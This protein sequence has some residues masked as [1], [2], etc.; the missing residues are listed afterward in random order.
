MSGARPC[1]DARSIRSPL[2]LALRLGA[3]HVPRN[4]PLLRPLL[5]ARSAESRTQRRPF[6]REASSPQVRLIDCPC[7]NAGSTKRFLG[8]ESFAVIGP[9]ALNR[10]AFYPVSVRHPAGL[11]TPLLSASL[12]RFPLCGS[13][14][15]LRPT[16][17]RTSTSKSMFMLGTPNEKSPVEGS[18]RTRIQPDHSAR[19]EH[20]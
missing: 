17:Q 13:L 2:R 9:L 18:V 6:R 15:S 3:V 16:P 1:R 11:A 5:T 7:T 4:P 12:S 14:G 19:A 20:P 8:R 10:P